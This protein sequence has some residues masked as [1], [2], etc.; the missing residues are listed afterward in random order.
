MNRRG[1]G[2]TTKQ[3]EALARGGVFVWCNDKLDYPKHL[4]QKL[5]RPDIKVVG[6]SW[7]TTER[8]LG[9]IF[10]EVAVDHA[11]WD[12]QPRRAMPELF[13]KL[14]WLKTRVRKT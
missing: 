13:S 6:P 4:Q 8:W 3:M 2:Q 1:I 9:L 11:M 5:N 7:V 14:Q 12:V 10:P